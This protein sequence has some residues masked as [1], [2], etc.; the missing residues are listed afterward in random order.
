MKIK[1]AL[2]T[3]AAA[4]GSV[5]DYVETPGG[6]VSGASRAGSGGLWLFLMGSALSV[7]REAARAMDVQECMDIERL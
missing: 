7:E 6:Q 5:E 1:V 3:A 2:S 4:A